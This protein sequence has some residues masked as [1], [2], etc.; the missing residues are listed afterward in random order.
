MSALADKLRRARERTVEV[1]GR[2]FTVRRPTD[3]EAMLLSEQ[4]GLDLVRRYVTGW[5]LREIDLIPGGGPDAVPF[6]AGLWADWVD[7]QPDL[8]GPLA[9]TIVAAYREHTEA[10]EHAAKN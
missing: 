5:D 6:E 7:D 10:R 1:A 9:E 8:W 2:R 3:A 4:T